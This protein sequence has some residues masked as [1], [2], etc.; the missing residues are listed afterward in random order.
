MGNYS[1]IINDKL[2]ILGTALPIYMNYQLLKFHDFTSH[3]FWVMLQKKIK[4]ENQQ[5]AITSK[6]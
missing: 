4:Y 3:T 1:K 6:I 2:T 5:R